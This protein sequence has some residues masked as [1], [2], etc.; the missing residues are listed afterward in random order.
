MFKKFVE[1]LMD[2]SKALTCGE[3]LRN[4]VPADAVVEEWK[5]IDAHNRREVERWAEG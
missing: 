4:G 3:L 2:L 5:R 1:I